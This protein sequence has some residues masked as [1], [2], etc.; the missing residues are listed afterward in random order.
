[1]MLPLR[2]QGC[3]PDFRH[4][5]CSPAQLANLELPFLDLLY[6]FNSSNHHRRRSE[7]LQSQHRAKST[8]HAPVILFDGVV[9]ILTTPHLHSLRQLAGGLQIGRWG[10]GIGVE[11]DL[12]RSPLFT[13]R[14]TQK[15][16]A[17]R[18]VTFTAQIEIRGLRSYQ[19]CP[20]D[21]DTSIRPPALYKSRPQRHEL[22]T[23]RTY[24]FHR[25]SNSRA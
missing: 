8:L 1:M 9:Q 11:R 5:C 19:P 21:K 17:C 7:T 2:S 18:D 10:S 25:F 22:A 15:I 6:Q 12:R 23:V 24:R 14:F 4:G 20:P 3:S 13:H 16:L